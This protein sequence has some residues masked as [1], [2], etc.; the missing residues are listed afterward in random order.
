MLHAQQQAAFVEAQILVANARKL[1]RTAHEK[2]TAGLRAST[3]RL[4]HL[5]QHHAWS[6]AA[7]DSP[8][9]VAAAL[10][11]AASTMESRAGSRSGKP[12]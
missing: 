8:S 1:E 9:P 4:D 10:I 7:A 5:G 11:Q 12:G 3:A 2:L 6:R